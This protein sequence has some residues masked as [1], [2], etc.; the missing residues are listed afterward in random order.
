[1]VRM[2][3]LKVDIN[4]NIIGDDDNNPNIDLDGNNLSI[5]DY[6]KMVMMIIRTI[7]IKIL[8]IRMMSKKN[9]Y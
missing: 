3:L 9:S 4:T 5:N 2:L 7:I 6:W 8:I 1:M